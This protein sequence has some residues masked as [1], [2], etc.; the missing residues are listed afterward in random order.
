MPSAAAAA[1]TA[2]SERT[3]RETV[4]W[5]TL[6]NAP[7][8]AWERLW[9]KATTVIVTAHR[10]AQ[11]ATPPTWWLPAATPRGG[12]LDKQVKLVVGQ[13]GH[14]L[15]AQRSLRWCRTDSGMAARSL[16]RGV[17]AL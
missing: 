4:G 9:R 10:K 8:S 12:T 13:A 15:G 6:K 14:G 17:V 7:S 1:T 11:R 16:P 5:L 2:A 3:T